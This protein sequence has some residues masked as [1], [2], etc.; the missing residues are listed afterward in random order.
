M[1]SLL[2]PKGRHGQKYSL[3]IAQTNPRSG[4]A[5]GP[6]HSS[7]GPWQ[8][9]FPP[10]CISC[11]SSWAP[12]WLCGSAAATLAH[13]GCQERA[14]APSAWLGEEGCP[15]G[16]HVP[17]QDL[18]GSIRGLLRSVREPA[19]LQLWQFYPLRGNGKTEA[20]DLAAQDTEAHLFLSL[21]ASKT[22]F[23]LPLPQD[24]WAQFYSYWVLQIQLLSHLCLTGNNAPVKD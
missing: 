7:E 13:L 24:P 16:K 1:T 19:A 3:V 10:A 2:G 22:H 21:V 9:T 6:L 8:F 5:E 18:L 20:S 15:D 11:T 14:L 23:I 4:E 12:G 17:S